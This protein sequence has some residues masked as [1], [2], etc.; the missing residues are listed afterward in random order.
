MSIIQSNRKLKIDLN[1]INLK[2]I[3]LNDG[4]E[5]KGL[6]KIE[7]DELTLIAL[8]DSNYEL[9]VRADDLLVTMNGDSK[10]D[11]AVKGGKL[12]I[13]LN[14]NSTLKGD[15]TIKECE[16]EVNERSEFEMDGDVEDLKLTATGSAKIK[17][18]TLR[19][20]KVNVIAA[21]NSEIE[22]NATKEITLYTKDKSTFY[23]Y[24]NPEIKIEGFKDS[25][26]II[27]E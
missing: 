5:L 21:D 13:I 25:S 17:A 16:L 14:D 24:G 20:E 27:K 2:M 1:V 22:L 15:M 9:D 10:G 12:A 7:T 26:R 23:L 6:N 18:R 19:A 11:L 4:A 3:T 8:D